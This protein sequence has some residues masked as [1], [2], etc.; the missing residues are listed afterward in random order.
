MPERR[1]EPELTQPPHAD[2]GRRGMTRVVER[3]VRALLARRAENDRAKTRSERIAD[4]ITRFAGSMT[5]V[6]IHLVTYAAWILVNLGLI[7]GVPRF[8]PTFVILAMAASVEAIFLSTFVLISQNRMAAL[9]D[10]RADLDLHTSLLSEH[11][12]TR[13]LSLVQ[14]M[15]AR[16]DIREAEDPELDELARDVH[17]EK[18]LDKIESNEEDFARNGGRL[19]RRRGREQGA[20]NEL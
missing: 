14:Q 18:V 20:G 8:D 7:P 16:M 6:Y 13:M 19:H 17:P 12:I 4:G 9:A 11:E 3:N 2:E 10:K 5:Y 1:T 15:A